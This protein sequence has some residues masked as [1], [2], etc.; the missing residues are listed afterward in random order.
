M[1]RNAILSFMMDDPN[2]ILR[3]VFYQSENKSEPVR[4]WLKSLTLEEK[5]KL[6][7]EIKT[8]QF[9]WPLGMLLVRKMGDNL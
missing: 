3:V 9:G 2:L 7:E 6:G 1:G 5:R 4:D 8:V